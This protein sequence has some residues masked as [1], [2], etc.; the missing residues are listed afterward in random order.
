[1]KILGLMSGTSHIALQIARIVEAQGIKTL[2]V[3]GKKMI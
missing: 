2:L 1:M 3:T